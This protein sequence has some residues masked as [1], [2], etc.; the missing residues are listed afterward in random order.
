MS[1]ILYMYRAINSVI[2][3]VYSIDKIPH[4]IRTKGSLVISG[5]NVVLPH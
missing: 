3:V 1:A 5:V 2:F 4:S